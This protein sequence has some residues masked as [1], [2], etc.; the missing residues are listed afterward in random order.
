MAHIGG[1]VAGVVLIFL[2]GGRLVAGAAPAGF[3]GRRM[4]G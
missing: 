1:F 3:T 2:F 4:R